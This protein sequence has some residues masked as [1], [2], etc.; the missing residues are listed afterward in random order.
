MNR[1]LL[2]EKQ[3]KIKMLDLILTFKHI[4]AVQ[5]RLQVYWYQQIILTEGGG[6]DWKDQGQRLNI[7]LEH[8]VPNS[9]KEWVAVILKNVIWV[10]FTAL[11]DIRFAFSTASDI[12]YNF[13]T[14][15]IIWNSNPCILI[16]L[17]TYKENRNSQIINFNVVYLKNPVVTETKSAVQFDLALTPWPCRFH[18]PNKPLCVTEL[19]K[20]WTKTALVFH[21]TSINL[22]LWWTESHQICHNS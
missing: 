3:R 6:F 7:T 19:A 10:E 22:P 14:Q 4:N 18:P 12:K 11:F 5:K 21:K 16:H 20:C 2:Q 9:F 13:N 8:T 1:C 15:Y 17:T